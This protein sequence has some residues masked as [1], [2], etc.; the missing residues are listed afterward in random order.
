LRFTFWVLK[1]ITLFSF[2][3]RKKVNLLNAIKSI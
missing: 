3:V 1:L 2:S